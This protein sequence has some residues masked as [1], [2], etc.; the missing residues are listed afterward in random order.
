MFFVLV[1]FLERLRQYHHP[2]CQEFRE[3]RRSIDVNHTS[4][5]ETFIYLYFSGS[6][7]GSRFPGFPYAQTLSGLCDFNNDF[8]Y[9][10]GK[11]V[12]NVSVVNG[13]KVWLFVEG[14]STSDILI[15]DYFVS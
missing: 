3:G 4:Q 7:S 12:E 10:E 5:L 6:D 2:S 11:F 13:W 9:V 15:C 14:A 1:P 8:L